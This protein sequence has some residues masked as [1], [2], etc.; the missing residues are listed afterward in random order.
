MHLALAPLRMVIVLK[1]LRAAQM[2]R[3]NKTNEGK[4]NTQVA[5]IWF[6]PRQK[7]GKERNIPRG[8]R[9]SEHADTAQQKQLL[10]ELANRAC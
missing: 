6:G 1:T 3:K 9:W 2:G 7:E 8:G 5:L 10:E 4:K